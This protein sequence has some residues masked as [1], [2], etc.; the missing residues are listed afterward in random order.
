MCFWPRHVPFVTVYVFLGEHNGMVELLE[1]LEAR[2]LLATGEY[3]VIYTDL[4]SF[5]HTLETP[6]KYFTSEYNAL[7]R[8][9][10]ISQMS[11]KH[12]EGAQ[13]FHKWVQY[14]KK[15]LKYSTSE[16]IHQ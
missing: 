4:K 3:I 12:Q 2:G 10:N 11:T 1:N 15:V 14:I 16:K 9:S 8:C 5:D 13:I 7:R 6:H